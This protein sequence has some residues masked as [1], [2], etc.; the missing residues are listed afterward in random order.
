MHSVYS[1]GALP[2]GLLIRRAQEAGLS[3]LSITDH[4]NVGCVDEAAAEARALGMEVIPGVELSVAVGEQDV[5]ILAYFIDHRHPRLTEYLDLF[6]SERVKRAGR[7]VERLNDLK[8]P[9]TLEAVLERAGAGSVGRPHIAN[10]LLEE[11]LTE[12]YHEAFLK[13]IGNGKPAYEKK[14]QIAPREA[15]RLIEEAGGLSFVAHPGN[16]MEERLL[17]R[18]IS[19]GVD[20][21]EVIHPSHS[22]ERVAYYRGIVNEYFLLASGGSDFHGGRRND[23][24]SLGKYYI[25]EKDVDMMRHQLRGPCGPRPGAGQRKETP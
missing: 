16:S 6:R 17:H 15:F 22:P 13:Y 18:L 10:A 24:E 20:G 11:G 5:H 21:I 23:Q 14:Y 9:L 2:V 19:E 7:I 12:S 3:V 8:I 25:S 1:D 4:D